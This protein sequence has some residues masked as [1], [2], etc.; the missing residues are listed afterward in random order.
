MTEARHWARHVTRGWEK[1]PD[2]VERVA[3]NL[4]ELAANAVTHARTP[5]RVVLSPEGDGIRIEVTDASRKLP[6]RLRPP[7]DGT[8]GRG[9]AMVQAMSARTGVTTR[10]TLGKSVWAVV[11]P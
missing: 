10:S 4:T 6:R 11:E 3:F 8:G 7:I 9:M 1:P 2:L 5:F